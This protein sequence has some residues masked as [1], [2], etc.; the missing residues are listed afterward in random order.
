MS[1]SAE[2]E[3][4]VIKIFSDKKYSVCSLKHKDVSCKGLYSAGEEV[5]IRWN[6]RIEKGIVEF[7]DGK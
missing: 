4:A 6:K 3:F 7:A 1:S 2:K 5:A